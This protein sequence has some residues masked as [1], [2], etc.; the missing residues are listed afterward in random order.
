MTPSHDIAIS[1][2]KYSIGKAAKMIGLSVHTLR[3]YELNGLVLP[4]RN[5]GKQ[6]RY[7]EDDLERLRCVHRAI[8][9]EKISIQGIRHMLAMVPCWALINCPEEDRKICLAYLGTGG[10]CWEM[11]HKNSMCAA[12]ECRSCKVYAKAGTCHS[13]KELLKSTL[14]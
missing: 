1:E 5:G 13:L 6:R 12:L 10:P 4:S 8:N 11:K 2:A 9:E 3:K 7:S 14:L